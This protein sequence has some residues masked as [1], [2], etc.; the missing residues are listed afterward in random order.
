MGRIGQREGTQGCPALAKL[1]GRITALSP[2]CHNLS[3]KAL[4]C[5]EVAM[6]TEACIFF[7]H[8]ANMYRTLLWARF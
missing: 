4:F 6:R 1:S 3:F 8:S 2:S 5:Y 7:V